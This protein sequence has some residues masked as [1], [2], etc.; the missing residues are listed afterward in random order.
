[1]DDA[2]RSSGAPVPPGTATLTAPAVPTPPAPVVRPVGNA[3]PTVRLTSV[4]RRLAAR[5]VALVAWD[6][7]ALRVVALSGTRLSGGTAMAVG[8]ACAQLDRSPG[9]LR[10]LASTVGPLAV[11]VAPLAPSGA[12][13][14]SALVVV[15]PR[16][17][18]DLS[19]DAVGDL[20]RQTFSAS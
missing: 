15:D 16:P 3:D 1:M 2:A 12:G 9:T 4:R 6:E 7:Q 19:A 20:L 11:H 10:A 5:T 13:E 8:V 18:A 17:M 14:G